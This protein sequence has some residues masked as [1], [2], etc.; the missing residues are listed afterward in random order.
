MKD[1]QLATSDL[2]LKDY[3]STNENSKRLKPFLSYFRAQ[4]V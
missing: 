4:R 3:H 2:Q 1:K